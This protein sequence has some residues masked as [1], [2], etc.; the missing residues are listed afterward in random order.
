MKINIELASED[1]KKDFLHAHSVIDYF[2][3]LYSTEIKNPGQQPIH[4]DSYS[5]KS[6]NNDSN[7]ISIVIRDGSKKTIDVKEDLKRHGFTYYKYKKNSKKEDPRYTQTCGK[8]FWN[9]IKDQTCFEGLN[10]WTSD[11]G[12]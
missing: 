4:S 6:N 2:Q 9:G 1:T 7:D 12:E 10:I 11:G 8:G 5:N 3:N